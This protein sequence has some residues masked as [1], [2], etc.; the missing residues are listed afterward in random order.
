[1][2]EPLLELDQERLHML[3]PES[4]CQRV[5]GVRPHYFI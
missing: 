1:M 2:A 4:L 5:V 3:V